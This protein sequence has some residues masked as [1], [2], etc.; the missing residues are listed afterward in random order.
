VTYAS[1]QDLIDRFGEKE[2]IQLTDRVNR[3]QTTIDDTVVA[4]ALADAEA[5]ADG[6]IATRYTLPLAAVPA[7]L[8]RIVC[9]LARF[10]LHGKAAEKD[11]PVERANAAAIRWLQD[12]SKGTVTLETGAGSAAIE[13]TGGVRASPGR[14]VMTRDSLRGY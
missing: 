9:D 7:A 8:V 4:R 6:Y 2:L 11:S 3:P 13:A 10:L 5:L 1:A 14:R 12:V